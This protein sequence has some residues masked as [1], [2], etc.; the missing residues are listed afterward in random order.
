METK[1]EVAWIGQTASNE[2]EDRAVL[3]YKRRKF[4]TE[5]A[6]WALLG[7]VFVASV[8]FCGL[9]MGFGS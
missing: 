5:V 4:W 2:A 3:R 7:I 9:Y 1:R 8:V 6:L